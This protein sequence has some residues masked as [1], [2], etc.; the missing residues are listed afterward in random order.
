M[1]SV[2]WKGKG[3]EGRSTDTITI[4]LLREPGDIRLFTT[5]DERDNS[6]LNIACNTERNF[7]F[8]YFRWDL[9]DLPLGDDLSL[10]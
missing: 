7:F 6:R 4:H 9:V 3:R 5:L 8:S 2:P 10:Q 1:E